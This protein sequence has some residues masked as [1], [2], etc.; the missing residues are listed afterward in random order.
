MQ[1]D[2]KKRLRKLYEESLDYART[3][4]DIK[5]STGSDDEVDCLDLAVDYLIARGVSALPCNVGNTV[6]EIEL[7]RDC[8]GLGVF[9]REVSKIEITNDGVVL[10][11]REWRE[12]E[13]IGEYRLTRKE[14]EFAIGE[15][16]EKQAPDK[17]TRKDNFKT[18]LSYFREFRGITQAELAKRADVNFRTLQD[19]EQGSKNI[20]GARVDTVSRLAKALGCNVNDLIEP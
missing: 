4:R 8:S 7:K 17:E 15:S 13:R 1:Y 19:Y 18:K 5:I 16:D 6:Y 20:N 3:Y 12:H 9:E 10:Y 14:A 2:M 11:H